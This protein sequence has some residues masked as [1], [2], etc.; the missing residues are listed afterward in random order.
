VTAARPLVDAAWLKEHLED[1]DLRLV[2]VSPERLTYDERHLPGAVYGDLHR[3]LAEPGRR[4]ETGATD[5][6]WLVPDRERLAATLKGWGVGPGDRVVFYD[7]VGQNRRAIR[8]YWLLRLYRWPRERVHVLDGGLSAWEGAGLATTDRVDPVRS[9]QPVELG[10]MDPDLIAT[11]EQVRAWSD[12]SREAE[13][14]PIR[15][16]D[17]RTGEEYRGE[18]SRAARGGHVPGAVNLPFASFLADDNRFRP[19][20]ELRALADSAAGGDASTIRA[21]YCQGGVRAALA[22]FVLSELLGLEGARNYA[23]SWEEW[24]NLPDVPIVTG[25]QRG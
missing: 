5:R 3:E 9:T 14:G 4:P 16:L 6:E 22:W 24:G 2:H 25:E 20:D 19:P 1:L 21:T 13:G 7:D 11:A 8:G 12:Q 17:V 23:G 15:L 10:E 18:D